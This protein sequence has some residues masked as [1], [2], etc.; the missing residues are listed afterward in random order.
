M[1]SQIA[2]IQAIINYQIAVVELYRLEG[3]L[4]LRSGIASPGSEPVK[5]SKTTSS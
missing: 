2:E 4:L 3:T 1:Q 5:I